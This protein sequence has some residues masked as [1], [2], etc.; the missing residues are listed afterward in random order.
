[1][2]CQNCGTVLDDGVLF[3]K[4]CGFKVEDATPQELQR[5]VQSVAVKREPAGE[6]REKEKQSRRHQGKAA[7]IFLSILFSVFIVFLGIGAS[8]T[9]LLRHVVSE[10][11]I[12]STVKAL[13][14]SEAK[15]CFIEGSP[16][17]TE[18]IQ[19]N[20][21]PEIKN[22]LT[23]ERLEKLLGERFVRKFVSDKINNYVGDILH[24]TGEG[25]I[26]GKEIE[27]LLEKNKE[28]ISKDI[29]CW[30]DDGE[31]H[32]IVSRLGE[33]L[34]QTDLS[35]YRDE[36][37]Q[38]FWLIRCLA[39]YWTAVVFLALAALLLA[40]I[41]FAQTEKANGLI[42]LGIDMILVGIFSFAVSGITGNLVTLLN[43]T[44]G[45]GRKFWKTLFESVG[46]MGIKQ[47]IVL[48]AVGVVCFLIAWV[49]KILS[50]KK[51][52]AGVK[53]HA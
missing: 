22:S 3:C 15:L 18:L 6:D 19:D 24:N 48:A 31:I 26:A 21:E 1:M 14:I 7:R 47:G 2:F 40:G 25:I 20:A 50:R 8:I 17:I 35:L 11:V 10:D 52:N 39:S 41:I 12:N 16:T 30:I 53:I 5:E 9:F 44:V 42:Y 33:L 37:P 38:I 45:L 29:N 43:R 4:E 32:Q 28:T 49:L 34:D 46:N 13:D 27:K 51:R 23:D 36:N